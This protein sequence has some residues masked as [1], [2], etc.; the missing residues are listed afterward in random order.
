MIRN[1]DSM[2]CTLV[3]HMQNIKKD[4]D[5][6]RNAKVEFR[7]FLSSFVC[8]FVFSLFYFF[9][10]SFSFLSFLVSLSSIRCAMKM[11]HLL[12]TTRPSHSVQQQRTHIP[13]P[14]SQRTP[15]IRSHC[16]TSCVYIGSL[17]ATHPTPTTSFRI[18]F[19]PGQSKE[20]GTLYRLN[21]FSVLF[22]II[23][24]MFCALSVP[25][26]PSP[27]ISTVRAIMWRECRRLF[28]RVFIHS[29]NSPSRR[30]L[31]A[32]AARHMQCIYMCHVFLI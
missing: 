19:A 29:T 6:A 11:W 32:A 14:T 22:G 24:Y 2:L 21:R 7:Y 8:D 4:D 10:L 3:V 15:S 20:T 28:G 17:A 26:S 30:R 25:S 18:V 5:V 27:P 1:T 23:F 12:C 16:Y 13:R 9:F 31:P